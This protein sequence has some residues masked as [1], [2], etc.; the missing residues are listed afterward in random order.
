MRRTLLGLALALPLAAAACLGDDPVSPA[1]PIEDVEFASSLGVNLAASTELESGL[2]YRDITAGVG[3]LPELGDTLYVSYDGRLTDGTRFDDGEL[4][5]I[6]GRS[7]VIAGFQ[8]GISL[9]RLGGQRQLIIPPHLAYGSQ[10]ITIGTGADRVVI[11]QNSW[12]VFDVTLDSI[13]V[14]TNTTQ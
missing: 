6:L 14:S 7:N 11:R 12:L 5:F 3:V 10:V 9:M 1:L 13:K 4:A 8:Q 2:W